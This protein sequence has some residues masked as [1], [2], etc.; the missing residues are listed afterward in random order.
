M[1]LSGTVPGR[2]QAANGKPVVAVKDVQGEILVL[3]VVA[4][5]AGQDLLAMRRIIGR[6]EVDDDERRAADGAVRMNSSGK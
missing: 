6:V 1:G 4:V 3:I 5:K 2:N